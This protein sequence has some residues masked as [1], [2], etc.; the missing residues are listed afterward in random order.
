L[1]VDKLDL[2]CVTG[3]EA[4]KIGVSLAHHEVAVSAVTAALMRPSIV[5]ALGDI[6]KSVAINPKR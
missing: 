6:R 3:L 2:E 1:L 5:R 4:E